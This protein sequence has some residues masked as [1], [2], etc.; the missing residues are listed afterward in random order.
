MEGFE[1]E[2]LKKVDTICMSIRHDFGLL[3]NREKELLRFE[4]KEYIHAIAKELDYI[5]KDAWQGRG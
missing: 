5:P 2:M 1:K 3:P 4:A